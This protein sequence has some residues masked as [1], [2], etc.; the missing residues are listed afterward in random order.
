MKPSSKDCVAQVCTKNTTS[1]GTTTTI[2]AANTAK[3]PLALQYQS[4]KRLNNLCEN[5]AIIG[6]MGITASAT[7]FLC[8][9]LTIQWCNEIIHH[10]AY[11]L[12]KSIEIERTRVM[13]RRAVMITSTCTY[14]LSAVN[15]LINMILLLGVVKL[16]YKLLLPWILFHG[17]LFGFFIH[18]ALYMSI[19]SL[20]VDFRIFVIL[21][22]SFTMILMIFYKISCEV[23]QLYKSLRKGSSAMEEQRVLSNEE[24]V[25]TY[26]ILQSEV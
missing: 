25:N 24:R 5:V 12:R 2:T 4:D 17:F 22:A 14:F 26:L 6:W 3:E 15:L 8:S 19:T 23:F 13:L 11:L 20:L 18:L 7:L 16:K 21:F 9:G 10:F 1:I